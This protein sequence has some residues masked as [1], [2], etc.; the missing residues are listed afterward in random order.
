MYNWIENLKYPPQE[1]KKKVKASKKWLKEEIPKEDNRKVL[2]RASQM[3]ETTSCNG[4]GNTATARNIYKFEKITPS[5]ES[6]ARTLSLGTRCRRELRSKCIEGS[7]KTPIS[8]KKRG[9]NKK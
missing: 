7:S 5:K 2:L 1:D 4:I 9:L 3:F 8:K 6:D